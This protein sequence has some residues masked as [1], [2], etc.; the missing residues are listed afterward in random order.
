MIYLLR[1]L[2]HSP[3][4][5]LK[6]YLLAGIAL[7][8]T[9]SAAAAQ[10]SDV[11]PIPSVVS[12]T[13]LGT[14][15]Q[16]SV[17]YG[18]DG[19]FSAPIG[20]RSVWTFGD[21]PMSV[22]GA[23]GNSWDDNSLSWTTNLDASQGIDLN[24]DLLDR[25]SAPAEYLP[26]LAWERKYNYEH[27]RNHCTATPC[28][29][30]FAMWDG[31]VI[32]DPARNRVLFYYYELYRGAPGIQ[33]WETVGGGIAVYTPET[34]ITRP[35]ENPGSKTPTLLWGSKDQQ[36]NSGALVV[37]DTLFSYGCVGGFLVDNCMV[38]RVPLAD[39]LDLTR[40]TY[41]AGNNV[42][43][44]NPG[45]AVT[46]FQGG[47]AANQVFYNA[48]LGVYMNIYNPALNNDMYYMVSYTPWGPWSK[49]VFLFKGETPYSGSVNYTGQA[50]SEFAQGNGQTEYVTYAHP[51][52]FLREDLPLTQVVFGK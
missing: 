23:L 46:I 45:D 52:G 10:N 9:I 43:S 36:Y 49:G 25:T 39:A 35:I 50:H 12:V 27:D 41:Y 11:P 4:T 14:V 24:H 13:P 20:G 31:P 7:F 29:A 33:G 16:N 8:T 3:M 30:E 22:P 28:G 26:Y 38:A 6:F 32:N 21:T 42:W 19:T 34:G 48:Y 17:I 2:N 47:A 44:A 15:K 51:S 18:R 37:G 40:W 5:P 1:S